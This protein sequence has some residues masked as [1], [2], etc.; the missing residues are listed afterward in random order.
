MQLTMDK[1]KVNIV[2]QIIDNSYQ[3]NS[4]YEL[5]NDFSVSERTIRNDIVK[6]NQYFNSISNRFL[7][8]D[9]SG[10]VCLDESISIKEVK[11]LLE[12]MNLYD[13]TLS[14]VERL[15]VNICILILTNRYVTYQEIAK[16]M[17]VSRFTAIDDFSSVN[18]FL[19]DFDLEVFSL[20][21]KG[22]KIRGVETNIRKAIL[23][24]IIN[25]TELVGKFL[26]QKMLN[27]FIDLKRT[28]IEDELE[29]IHKIINEVEDDNK[30]Y[31]TDIS[32]ERLSYYLYFMIIRVSYG[33]IVQVEKK[34]D[35]CQK[36]EKV[37]IDLLKRIAQYFDLEIKDEE[38]GLLQDMLARL[39][40]IKREVNNPDIIKI[41]MLTRKFIEAISSFLN[42]NLNN[43]YN[44][45]MNLSSHLERLFSSSGVKYPEYFGIDEIVERNKIILKAVEENLEILEEYAE[46]DINYIDIKF[47]VVY[48]CVAIEKKKNSV[49]DLSVIIVCNNGISTS[50]LLKEQLLK[51]FDFIIIEVLSFHQLENVS[52]EN[53]DLIIS[54]IPLDYYRFE[55]IHVSP[56]LG[57]D[58]I[59]SIDKKLDDIKMD[60]I[61]GFKKI[62]KDHVL[63][64]KTK[65]N[66]TNIISLSKLLRVDNIEIDVPAKD[67]KDT[68]KKAAKILERNG[69][70]NQRY[71]E[72]MIKN[73]E[74][75]GP[76]IVISKGFAL[77]HSKYDQGVNRLAMSLIR[78]S[79]PIEYGIKELD[80]VEFV[81]VMSAIDDKAH[82]KALF[83]L[84]NI[85]KLDGFHRD[86]RK[87]ET[88]EN[89]FNVIAYY[90]QEFN[91]NLK[92]GG[93]C[94][95]S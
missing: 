35:S 89:L 18:D 67:W 79:K 19:G 70:I 16:F 50:Q 28:K 43:D 33:E 56:I 54:T 74:K 25:N 93:V 20:S 26:K 69:D 10:I 17:Y 88:S 49:N 37:A 31:F 45:F 85:L 52:L 84:V 3:K 83:T 78:L 40:Y 91:R 29:I 64:Q 1:R 8:L 21:N 5:A 46:K 61:R 82:L 41:Q 39:N 13:Y 90:E 7:K 77:P 30:T 48:I 60:S 72:S 57:I 36:K 14:K 75:N 95:E 76:Y 87:V 68:I 55:Y 94:N 44:F 2:H 63:P 86:I 53:A 11:K 51:Y 80:P 34:V 65:N 4:L 66:S 92:L 22:L 32:L 24:I 23:N 6:I 73:V 15:L 12:E 71:T 9:S 62:D 58:D 47:I 42:I 38:V 27:E 81:C 59:V